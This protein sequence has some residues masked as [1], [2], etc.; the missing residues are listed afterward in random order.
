MTHR[1][2]FEAVLNFE[3]TDRLPVVE[4]APYWDETLARWHGEGLPQMERHTYWECFGLDPLFWI[5]LGNMKPSAPAPACHGAPL[6]RNEAEYNAFQQ[7]LWPD[8][9]EINGVRKLRGI[10]DSPVGSDMI[11]VIHVQ[12][13]FW[14]PRTLFGIEQHLYAFYDSPELM[15]RMNEEVLAFNM[16]SLDQLLKIAQP[17]MV[18]IS[19]DL[20][21]NHG[22]MISKN[23]FDEFI[24]PYYA[25]LVPFLHQRGLKCFLDTDGQVSEL[26]PWFLEKGV[27]G[28]LPME[29]MAGNDLPRIRQKHPQ[30]CILGG[31][32]KTVMHKGETAIR[33]EFE[34]LLPIMKNGGYILGVDHQ[35]PPE[36]SLEN[37]YLFVRLLKEYCEQASGLKPNPN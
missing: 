8:F 12:G 29:R 28:I 1:E 23:Q 5:G 36:V 4:W 26:I 32:D 10:L 11:L 22:P 6:V 17:G 3:K 25:R 30:L 18:V 2:R 27:D 37:Y 20:S 16:K 14:F 33:A 13:F 7:H 35:T 15:C 24:A 31:F 34:R 21:Y 19:E 9:H